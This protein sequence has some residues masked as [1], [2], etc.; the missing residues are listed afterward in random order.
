MFARPSLAQNHWSL[1][2]RQLAQILWRPPAKVRSPRARRP[3]ANTRR[4]QSNLSWAG[5]DYPEYPHAGLKRHIGSNHLIAAFIA[6]ALRHLAI[7]ML[8]ESLDSSLRYLQMIG[9]RSASVGPVVRCLLSALFYSRFTQ[10]P[11]FSQK[12]NYTITIAAAVL[13]PVSK[14]SVPLR[15]E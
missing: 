8:V 11:L 7:I 9:A 14:G 15:K 13:E 6:I 10:A 12:A 2:F 1:I 4:Q 3:Q 5:F